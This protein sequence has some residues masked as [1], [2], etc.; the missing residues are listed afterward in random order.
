MKE[1]KNRMKRLHLIQSVGSPI[2]S[3]PLYFSNT[4]SFI[5]CGVDGTIN[6][7]SKKSSVDND[8]SVDLF[9][10]HWSRNVSNAPIFSS[11][12]RVDDVF[13][14]IGCHDGF[15]RRMS[16]GDFEWEMELGSAVFS[17]CFRWQNVFFHHDMGQ[18]DL[19]FD[20][21]KMDNKILL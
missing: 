21:F 4:R 5:C 19:D 20:Y 17:T 7:F 9:T 8:E 12:C 10:L 11:P 14:I 16:Y 13:F 2:F 18:L 6:C 3:S 1:R 15:I